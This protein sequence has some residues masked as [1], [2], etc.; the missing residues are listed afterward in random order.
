MRLEIHIENAIER[1]KKKRLPNRFI[2]NRT[3]R[4]VAHWFN[5]SNYNCLKNY[6]PY[7]P[8]YSYDFA[9]KILRRKNEMPVQLQENTL[10]RKSMLINS[11]GIFGKFLYLNN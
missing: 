1:M 5:L 8:S 3:L 11:G 9:R 7:A 2:S 6:N 4:D 10:L